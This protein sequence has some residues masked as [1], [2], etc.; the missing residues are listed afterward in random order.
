LRIIWLTTQFP[1]GEKNRNGM[2][3]YRTVKE[4]SKLYKITVIV[5]HPVIPP[6]LP[7]IKNLSNW[8]KIYLEWKE[9]YPRNPVKPKDAKDIDIIYS[10]YFRPPRPKIMFLESWGALPNI[11]KVINKYKNEKIVIHANWIFPEGYLASILFTKYNYPY[12]LTLR[13]SDF[14][15]IGNNSLN[16]K[17]AEKTIDL[18]SKI[19]AVSESLVNEGKDKGIKIPLEKFSITNNFYDF[20]KFHIKSKIESKKELGFNRDKK[21]IFFAG[22]L[23]KIKNIYLLLD[24]LIILISKEKY[25]IVLLLAGYGYEENKLKEYVSAN[26]LTE[27]VIFVGNLNSDELVEY[28]NAANVFCLPSFS[29]GLPNVVVETLMCGTPVVA[30]SVGG[31]PTIIKNGFNGYLIDPYSKESLT[32][33]L[34]DT[35]NKKWDREILRKSISFLSPDNII[36]QYSSIYNQILK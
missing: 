10:N 29:E 9:K 8:R 21:I 7:M 27:N 36:K 24:S 22:A 28:Y 25:N 23:R 35:L 32:N 19:T 31:I 15:Q 16:K 3:I 2:F 4:L 17:Y 5:L 30:A 34:E 14:K 13:G 12:I 33:A 6:I 11:K 1:V 26:N 20:K 18:A